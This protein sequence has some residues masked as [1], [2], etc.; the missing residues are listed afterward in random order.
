MSTE[1]VRARKQLPVKSAGNAARPQGRATGPTQ[2]KKM[3]APMY[4][5]GE[6]T[7]DIID[8]E[9]W[10]EEPTEAHRPFEEKQKK[11]WGFF[12]TKPQERRGQKKADREK[13]REARNAEPE[14]S[15]EEE[16]ELLKANV[17]DAGTRYMDALKESN[18]LAPGFN[19][20]Q[21]TQKL[22]MMHR[23]YG[24]LMVG[25]ALRPL[26][27]GVNPSAV[28][29]AM[30]TM[31]TMYVLSPT[32]R[33]TVGEMLDPVR[34]AVN[35]R[36]DSKAS[37]KHQNSALRA[38]K[39]NKSID[40]RNEAI[41]EGN[42][43]RVA[44]GEAPAEL[45]ERVSDDKY[46]SK[47]WRTRFEAVQFRERGN[48]EMHTPLSAGMTEVALGEQAYRLMREDGADVGKIKESYNSMV[49]HLYQQAEAD[50]LSR[51]EV[52]AASRAVLGQRIT[53]DPRTQLLVTGTAHGGCRMS[54]PVKRKLAGTDK[55]VRVWEGDFEDQLGE[56]QDLSRYKDPV[57]KDK[58]IGAFELR[59]PQPVISHQE[60]MANTMAATMGA[61]VSRG[62][63]KAFNDDIAAYMIG[64]QAKA[65]NFDG[66]GL[67][68]E[69][70]QRLFQSRTMLASMTSDGLGQE[71][72]QS[73]YSNAYVDAIEAV[74]EYF[75]EFSKQWTETYGEDWQDFMRQAAADPEASYLQ[76]QQ[77]P[78][79]RSE[80][81][82]REPPRNEQ[83]HPAPDEEYQP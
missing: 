22:D 83:A 36:I 80:Q 65:R 25:A 57:T 16:V 68:P 21:R 45:L 35:S 62:D 70:K 48:R 37:W 11:A 5:T 38:D 7:D 60:A 1:I 51:E 73:V 27:N 33:Q 58:L 6:A 28:V 4:N 47:Q 69:M 24:Q 15:R 10:V 44:R 42:L 40:T 2:T 29:S 46:M 56:K 67:N 79:S 43:E 12:D 14:L 77:Q 13:Q 63:M 39:K 71:Q 32:F 81:P 34:E 64:F 9:W 30:T 8:A 74:H 26:A 75:P 41:K 82:R 23:V 17:Q 53:D 49:S 61:A 52:A 50:G 72:Q 55:T 78:A 18:I 31:G 54:D 19:D 76:W 66:E 20:E 59:D 3:T